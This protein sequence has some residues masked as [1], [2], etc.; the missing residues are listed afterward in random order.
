MKDSGKI[1]NAMGK[2]NK[3]FKKI[4][5]ESGLDMKEIF[6]KISFMEMVYIFGQMVKSMK[7][8]GVMIN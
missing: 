5:T 7:G 6:N 4:K 2:E 1:I 8:N 3:Y